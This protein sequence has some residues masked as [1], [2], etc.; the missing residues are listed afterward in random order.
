MILKR[1]VALNGVWLDEVDDRIVIDGIEP[2]DGRENI[3]A[4]DVAGRYGQ[5][6]TR[7]RRSTVDMVIRFKMLEHGRNTVGMT[8]RSQLLEKINAWAS[9]GGYLTVNYKPNRRLNVI[10]TQAPG[11]G[12]LW[13]YTKEFSLAFRA[14]GVPYWEDETAIS[15]T[16]GGSSASGSRNIQIDGSAETQADVELAN[17]SGMV[18]NTASVSVGGKTMAFTSLGLR[19]GEV[20]VIDHSD[21]LVRIRIRNG[22]SY[23]SVMA[24]RSVSSANDL[25]ISPGVRSASYSADRAC[26]MTVSWRARYL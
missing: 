18:I 17:T 19:G 12:S 9:G 7:N 13:D 25:L 2:G 16:F 24:A 21:G 14:Y 3:A 8:E 20:L 1:R 23:R 26:R 11:E 10:L 4:A 15:Q 5:R 22:G 6:I